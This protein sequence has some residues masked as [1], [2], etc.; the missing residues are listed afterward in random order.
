MSAQR[1]PV[2]MEKLK[3]KFA[4]SGG[5]GGQNVNKVETKVT[6]RFNMKSCDWL[7]QAV[8]ERLYQQQ[9]FRI[10]KEHEFLIASERHRTQ[11][12]NL[13]DAYDKLQEIVKCIREAQRTQLLSRIAAAEKT[14][15][16]TVRVARRSDSCSRL[17]VASVERRVDVDEFE[18]LRF[19]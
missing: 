18:T 3:K 12:R 4:R 10:N 17:S 8:K 14:H 15:T 1:L 2:P 9:K 19:H 7:P 16:V 5:K 13:M 6:L 11:H